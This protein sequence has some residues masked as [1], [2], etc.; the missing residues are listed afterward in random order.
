MKS[1]LRRAQV[2]DVE[3]RIRITRE[4]QSEYVYIHVYVMNVTFMM[5]N[6]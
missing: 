1:L 3:D 6:K 2:A 4:S 5:K